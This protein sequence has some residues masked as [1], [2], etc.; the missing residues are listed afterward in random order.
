M[1]QRAED[2][3]NQRVSDARGPQAGLWENSLGLRT[4]P[5]PELA[6]VPLYWSV[7]RD[8]QQGEETRADQ[9]NLGVKP[10]PLARVREIHHQIA[11]LLAQGIRA[12][13]I[14]AIVGFSQSRISILQRDPSFADLVSFYRGRRDEI[15]ADLTSRLTSAT[16][17]ALTVLHERLV[18]NPDLISTD[19]LQRAV[20]SGLDRL[21]HGTKQTIDV[22]FIGPAVLARL[23]EAATQEGK[24][25]VRTISPE[26]PTNQNS[27]PSP[28]L[29]SASGIIDVPDE[30]I[31]PRASPADSVRDAYE[32]S[33]KPSDPPSQ[34]RPAGGTP[35]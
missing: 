8:L 26:E 16:L 9:R 32:S 20:N 29:G 18:D 13:E 5:E 28:D 7:V 15:G 25:A 31:V 22:N 12:V 11:R 1:D 27:K 33:T 19:E 30:D 24:V 17:D 35:I 34:G 4:G 23:K 2:L 3:L 14:S 6:D 10:I 21:G